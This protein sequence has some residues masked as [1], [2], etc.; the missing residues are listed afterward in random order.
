MTPELR[1][2]LNRIAALELD[3]SDVEV[4]AH[5]FALCAEYVIGRPVKI[6]EPWSNCLPHE[7]HI[8]GHKL[9]VKA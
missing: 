5:E 8:Y 3:G 2:T 1:A 4:T 9:V 7:L 6:V